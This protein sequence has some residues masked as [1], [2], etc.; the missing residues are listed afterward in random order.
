MSI[1]SSTISSSGG[2]ILY[3]LV[4]SAYAR[5]LP[6]PKDF[7]IMRPISKRWPLNEALAKKSNL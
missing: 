7:S 5:K 3:A 6:F 4:C 2:D 1:L